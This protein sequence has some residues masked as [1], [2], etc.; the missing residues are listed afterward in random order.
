MSFSAY[1]M[2]QLRCDVKRDMRKH[3]HVP[4]VFAH[5]TKPGKVVMTGACE[6]CHNLIVIEVLENGEYSIEDP[7][8]MRKMDCKRP[9]PRRVGHDR[10]R[11]K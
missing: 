7:A 6:T 4:T 1:T 10:R 9:Y 3:N 5:E 11:M 2:A 8:N